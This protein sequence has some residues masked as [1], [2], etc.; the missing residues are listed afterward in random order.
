[1]YVYDQQHELDNRLNTIPGL[2]KQTLEE[3]QK[4]LHE[5]NEWIK[6]YKSAAE[7]LLEYP[8]ITNVQM[9]LKARTN[10]NTKK[11]YRNPSHEDIAI[12]IPNR[13]DNDQR[14]PREVVLYRNQQENPKGNKTV[15]ISSL[16]KAYDPTAYPL[17][18]PTGNYGFDLDGNIM[19]NGVKVNPLKYYQ[20]KLMERSLD[21]KQP[22]LLNCGRLF[23][24]F[25]CDI[26]S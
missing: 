21:P 19:E 4:M 9:V 15:R 18:F 20:Y 6:L 24:E 23:Q 14:N 26:Y 7:T 13:A 8:A 2:N 3:L 5:N 10:E 11:V 1:M 12:I 16:H 22:T 17:L 25:L